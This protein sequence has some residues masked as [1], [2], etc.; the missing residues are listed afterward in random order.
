MSIQGIEKYKSYTQKQLYVD[1]HS[2]SSSQRSTSNINSF[3]HINVDFSHSSTKTNSKKEVFKRDHTFLNVENDNVSNPS[4]GK[5]ILQFA[6]LNVI[7][8]S[9]SRQN[10]ENA[11]LVKKA[12]TFVRTNNTN[13]GT[14][15]SSSGAK[16]YLNSNTAILN[17]LTNNNENTIQISQDPLEVAE[18]FTFF[19]NIQQQ[20][21]IEFD[22]NDV[23]A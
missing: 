5:V 13:S 23:W 15:T 1:V 16:T 7:N 22:D 14:F 2:E 9:Y 10:I 4:T 12:V 3:A 17:V 20:I 11:N 18:C 8:G 19:P 6:D 21:D